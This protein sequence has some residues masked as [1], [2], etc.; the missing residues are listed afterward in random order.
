MAFRIEPQVI[1]DVVRIVPERHG[2]ERGFL[3]ET[4]RRSAFVEAGI[5][6]SFVQENHVRSRPGVLRGL[7]YQVAPA[8]QGKLIRVVR[9]RIFDVTVDLREASPHRGDW[10]GV[11]LGAEGGEV[12]WVPPGFAH[13][14]CVLS[15]GADVAYKLT[16]EYHPEL[17]GGIRWDDPTLEI[18]W[19]IRDPVLSVKDRG[20]PP[21][22][23]I[24]TPF[25][26]RSGEGA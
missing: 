11:E 3:M 2:D 21:L 8:A 24:G 7:H 9:G 13:G 26:G 1:P 12:L 18:D 6:A 10:L 14:Y 19:P 4:Y 22:A 25:P 16:A 23:E 20:L 5:E 15:D 17:E